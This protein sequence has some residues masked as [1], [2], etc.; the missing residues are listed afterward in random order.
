MES[1]LADHKPIKY[2]KLVLLCNGSIA[3]CVRRFTRRVG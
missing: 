3:A 2:R 1:V